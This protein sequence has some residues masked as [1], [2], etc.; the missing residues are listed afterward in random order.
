MKNLTNQEIIETLEKTT[1]ITERLKRKI[2]H[3]N[4][5]KFPME[6]REV[7]IYHLRIHEEIIAEF[8]KELRRRGK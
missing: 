2:Q 3:L 4:Y 6:S 7:D 8:E 5:R 1:E